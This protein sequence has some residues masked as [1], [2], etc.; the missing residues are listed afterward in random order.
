M[1]AI[2]DLGQDFTIQG[3]Q[4]QV[5][6][7]DWLLIDYDWLFWYIMIEYFNRSWLIISLDHDWLLIGYDW[8]FE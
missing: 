1:F 7:H 2:F 5:S 8:L 3:F 6:D 4:Y